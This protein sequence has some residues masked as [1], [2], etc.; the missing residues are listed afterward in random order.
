MGGLLC[1]GEGCTWV[2]GIVNLNLGEGEADATAV[3]LL[4]YV[5]G[6]VKV[7]GPVISTLY[8]SPDGEVNRT[9]GQ[10]AQCHKW[11]RVCQYAAVCLD[12]ILE[13]LLDSIHLSAILNR[14][15]QVHTSQ[16][17]AA[18]PC[19][20]ICAPEAEKHPRRGCAQEKGRPEQHECPGR[21]VPCGSSPDH[22]LLSADDVDAARGLP[23]N[24]ASL[25]VIHGLIIRGRAGLHALHV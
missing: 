2:L 8:P 25:Q 23:L 18:H 20:D 10:V 14:Y 15:G 19:P 3:E 9:G 21:P 4:V 22:A 17:F 16:G 5:A 13:S 11:L 6:K 7:Y 24:L 1:A 12:D